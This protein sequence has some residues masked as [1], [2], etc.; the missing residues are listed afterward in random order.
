MLIQV[1]H[2]K[3]TFDHVGDDLWMLGFDDHVQR[4]RG[5]ETA[6]I[7]TGLRVQIGPMSRVMAD[8]MA[9]S[10]SRELS[11]VVRVNGGQP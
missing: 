7:P 11:P 3:V 10:M 5:G 9:K 1:A 4:Q 8:E 6:L 2:A